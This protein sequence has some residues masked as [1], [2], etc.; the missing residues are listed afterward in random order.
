M[1]K[2]AAVL[3]DL[4][5]EG[6][7]LLAEAIDRG[8]FAGVEFTNLRARVARGRRLDK[9]DPRQ[10]WL[11]F[12]FEGAWEWLADHHPT[13]RRKLGQGAADR[14]RLRAKVLDGCELLA[15]AIQQEADALPAAA[16][17][18]DETAYI[19]A[20]NVIEES[21]ELGVKDFKDLR[22]ILKD[23]PQIKTH[24]PSK[25]RLEVHAG[26]WSRYKR[27]LHTALDSEKIKPMIEA[28]EQRMAKE[29]KDKR[30]AGE[31]PA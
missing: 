21:T 28:V 18:A 23:N 31:L 11:G 27:Q 7:P 2:R 25:Q 19:P 5:R 13:F 22:R 6:A 16:S 3:T 1:P 10:V 14:C 4:C 17:V 30:A 15:L 8:A 29:R 26:D 12:W 24:K 9:L 20:T